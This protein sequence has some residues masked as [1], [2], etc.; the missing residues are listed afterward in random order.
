MKNI[1]D[2]IEEYKPDCEQEVVDKKLIQEYLKSF[3]NLFTREN[4]LVHMTASTF[5]L[6][7]DRNKVLM[8]FHNIYNSWGWVG[9]HAD[10][11]EDLFK[12]IKKE[13]E[14]E[15][16]INEITPIV[17]GIFSLEVLPVASHFRKGKYVAA[18]VHISIDYL[19]EADEDEKIRIK[20]DENSRINWI[21]LEN[22][23]SLSTEPHMKVVYQKLIDKIKK[24][25]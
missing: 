18:H 21:P 5:I 6:N 20:E 17:D 13:I 7:K 2:E 23:V 9:G 10:G 25:R 19:F 22:V 24:L 11:D 3:E 8:I 15:T 4:C 1:R 14:E 16:G 12:V